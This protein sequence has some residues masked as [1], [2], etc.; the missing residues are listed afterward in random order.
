M[1]SLEMTKEIVKILDAKKAKDLVAMEVGGLTTIADYFVVASGSSNT[2]VR[3]LADEVDE[4]LS[5]MGIE[6]N[7]VE[8]Y[9]SCLWVVLDY[10]QVIVHVFLDETREFYSLE[11][12]WADAPKVDLSDIIKPE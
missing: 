5:A 9:Q 2:Q 3:A 4:K 11:R 6:P 12:L 1:T 8:G 7:R 10:A